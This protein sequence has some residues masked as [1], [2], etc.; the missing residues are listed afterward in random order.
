[1]PLSS[2]PKSLVH[3]CRTWYMHISICP[4]DRG[5]CQVGFRTYLQHQAYARQRIEKH[6]VGRTISDLNFAKDVVAI[7][8]DAVVRL[9]DLGG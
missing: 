4:L 2:P 7:D 1:M 8:V 9:C 5:T 6:A 3:L